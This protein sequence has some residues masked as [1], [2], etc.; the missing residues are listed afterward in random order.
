MTISSLKKSFRD[1]QLFKDLQGLQDLQDF[2]A[3]GR[4]PSVH[5]SGDKVLM[6]YE[7]TLV[8]LLLQ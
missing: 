7:D 8:L 2:Q 6:K 3:D 5:L 4:W 1:L